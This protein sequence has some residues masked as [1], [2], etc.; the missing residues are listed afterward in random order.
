MVSPIPTQTASNVVATGLGKAT[1]YRIG[2]GAERTL[3]PAPINSSLQQLS[4][5][6]LAALGVSI[7]GAQV[8]SKAVYNR[9]VVQPGENIETVTQSGDGTYGATLTE[10]EIK[11]YNNAG[12][13]SLAWC[14]FTIWGPITPS[15]F[16]YNGNATLRSWQFDGFLSDGVTPAT[17]GGPA[18]TAAA[19]WSLPDMKYFKIYLKGDPLEIEIPENLAP[20]VITEI[21]TPLTP[22]FPLND[23]ENEA[24]EDRKEILEDL[25][26]IGGDIVDVATLV[27]AI[28]QDLSAKLT[29][30][31]C[32]LVNEN[33]VW[34]NIEKQLVI[35]DVQE[36]IRRT[37]FSIS[38]TVDTATC[39]ETPAPTPV[40]GDTLAELVTVL[41]ANKAN[42]EI[43]KPNWCEIPGGG[44]ASPESWTLN[45]FPM[46][47]QLVLRMRESAV[48][49]MGIPKPRDFYLPRFNGNI[50][51]TFPNW[52]RGDYRCS[53]EGE[54][55]GRIV[56]YAMTALEARNIA[57][58]LAD[59]CDGFVT[60]RY[61]TGFEENK[62]VNKVLLTPFKSF[63]FPM[64]QGTG[65]EP[66]AIH[67]FE[68]GLS[69]P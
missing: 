27:D 53:V 62:V 14:C 3:P 26:E 31:I 22:E 56:I 16:D 17:V 65:L 49:H 7:V 52:T 54:L 66:S 33:S 57:D 38:T 45:N 43:G 11:I 47:N 58:N 18:S 64:G 25:G 6:K 40:D 29:C 21:P 69:W 2:Q 23:Y 48:G 51:D 63:L 12:L 1:S 24:E 46:V 37:V 60:R 19:R 61:V 10:Y 67:N 4:P 41:I 50:D 32:D 20:P 15:I 68:T 36:L 28:L 8:A 30:N 9:S 34:T 59:R 44:C 13:T 55:G 35:Q 42:I 39:T 5:A